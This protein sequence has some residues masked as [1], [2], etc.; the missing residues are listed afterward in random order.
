MQSAKCSSLGWLC[1]PIGFCLSRLKACRMQ[2]IS[3]RMRMASCGY[4]LTISLYFPD[5]DVVGTLQP[6]HACYLPDLIIH[7]WYLDRAPNKNRYTSN[8][9]QILR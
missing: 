4:M 1:L 9:K 5:S 7:L 3:D 2:A 6:W 8:V